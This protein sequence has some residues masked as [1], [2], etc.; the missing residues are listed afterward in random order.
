MDLRKV[1][2]EDNPADLLTKYSNSRD[3]MMQLVG[4]YCCKYLP[5]RAAI[6][7]SMRKG[8]RSKT[9]MKELEQD[10]LATQ[11]AE[12]EGEE[13]PV[14]PAKMPHLSHDQPELDTLYPMIRAVPAEALDPDLNDDE[15][16]A[17]LKH[18]QLLARRTQDDVDSTGRSLREGNGDRDDRHSK[19]VTAAMLV[20]YAADEQLPV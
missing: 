7:P 2:G 16:D 5:G 20:A 4:L 10:I 1:P 12:H 19:T 6:A 14:R 15:C 18:G 8:E 3:R 9:T 11:N 17:M 13:E